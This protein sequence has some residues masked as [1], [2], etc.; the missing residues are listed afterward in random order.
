[1][2]LAQ[3]LTRELE[4]NSL[5]DLEA[6]TGIS[7]AALRRIAN[8]SL[9][10]YPDLETLKKIAEAYGQPLWRVL[11]MAGLDLGLIAR[12]QRLVTNVTSLI[13]HEPLFRQLF[14]RM[15]DAKT[16]EIEAVLIYLEVCAF[17]L[18]PT[19]RDED[20]ELRVKRP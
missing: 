9:Q 12:N 6:K 20:N 4:G 5:R 16:E 10:G 1:M 3:F 15:I 18:L 7:H 17:K 8:G 19:W 11:E 14:E 13:E 2:N